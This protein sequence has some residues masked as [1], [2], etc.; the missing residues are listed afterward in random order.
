MKAVVAELLYVHVCDGECCVAAEALSLC[1]HA[2]VFGYE[3]QSS[4]DDVLST[5]AVAAS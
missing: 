4:K 5:L 1:Q 3:S 2:A